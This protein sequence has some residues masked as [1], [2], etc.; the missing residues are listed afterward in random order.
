MRFIHAVFPEE[1]DMRLSKLVAVIGIVSIPAWYAHRTATETRIGRLDWS[2]FLTEGQKH[3][4]ETDEQKERE[5][6]AA[7][8][9]QHRKEE[10]ERAHKEQTEKAAREKTITEK[11]QVCT[12]KVQQAQTA[13]RNYIDELSRF[14]AFTDKILV[15]SQ[16]SSQFNEIFT[17]M[18]ISIYKNV[19]S[20]AQ[21]AQHRDKVDRIESKCGNR[22]ATGELDLSVEAAEKELVHFQGGKRWLVQARSDLQLVLDNLDRQWPLTIKGQLMSDRFWEAVVRW[23]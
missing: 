22:I 19:W 5:A 12:A 4:R 7:L 18:F 20:E 9:E 16:T 11:I 17:P 23:K 14:R 15:S 13:Y 6:T 1:M 2:L 21:I 10:A 3:Q 8:L